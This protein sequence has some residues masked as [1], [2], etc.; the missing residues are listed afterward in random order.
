M[1]RPLRLDFWPSTYW[2]NSPGTRAA[3]AKINGTARR[4]A[5]L[6]SL[7][8]GGPARPR[9][10]SRHR[11]PTMCVLSLAHC[12]RCGS[13]PRTARASS[14]EHLSGEPVFYALPRR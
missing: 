14:G 4:G 9:T 1:G 3:L 7:V 10:C 2:P 6:R 11:Y 8:E 12:T 13:S 5:V